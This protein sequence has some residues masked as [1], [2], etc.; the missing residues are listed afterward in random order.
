MKERKD[1]QIYEEKEE[2]IKKNIKKLE[3]DL[4]NSY[5]VIDFISNKLNLDGYGFDRNGIH[6]ETKNEYDP[7]GFDKNGIHEYTKSQYDPNGFNRN[8]IHEYT[9]NQYD[10]Y[11]FDRNGI[12]NKTKNEYDPNGFNI[13]NI[14]KDA[15]TF[16][17]K[18]MLLIKIY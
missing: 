8:G 4:D 1:P 3:E 12:H 17:I 5:K 11:G 10:S 14:H 7:N 15:G 18:K 13:N 9:K 6:N 2:L 16:L